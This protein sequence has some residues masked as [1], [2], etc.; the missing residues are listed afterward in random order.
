MRPMETKPQ[1]GRA[2]YQGTRKGL[3]LMVAALGLTC[4]SL[5]WSHGDV[6]PQAVDTTGLPELGKDWRAENPFRGNATA[7]KIGTSAFNQNCARCHGIEAI[8]GGIA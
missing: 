6:T 4:A 3:K 7:I 1:T 8:S 2:L 5:A